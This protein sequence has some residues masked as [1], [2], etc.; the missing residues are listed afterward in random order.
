VSDKIIHIIRIFLLKNVPYS[1]K[2][3][4]IGLDNYKTEVEVPS[5]QAEK[6][7]QEDAAYVKSLLD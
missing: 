1:R 5:E 2:E 4:E 6:F 7:V 3:E